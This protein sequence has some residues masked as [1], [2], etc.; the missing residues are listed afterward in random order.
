MRRAETVDAVGS[1]LG[2]RSFWVKPGRALRRGG[3]AGGLAM[4]ALLSST[5][6]GH[7]FPFYPSF[8]PQE[9]R[10]AVLAP[11][12]AGE[13]LARHR[14]HAYVGGSPRFA[15]APPPHLDH[16]RSLASF[17]VVTVNPRSAAGRTPAARCATVARVRAAFSSADRDRV[18]HGWPVTPYHP[19]YLH[20][21][22]RIAPPA[23]DV[24][25]SVPSSLT[26][27]PSPAAADAI[28]PR[29]WPRL[30]EGW[31]VAIDEVGIDDVTGIEGRPV[32]GWRGPPWVKEGW[33]QAYRLLS[34]GLADGEDRRVATAAFE[35][36]VG[37]NYVGLVERINLERELL[38]RLTRTCERAV[39]GYRLRREYYNS[40]YSAGVENIAV[41][42]QRGLNAGTAVRTMKLKDFPWNGWL[43]LGI[44]TGFES[45]WNP[46]AGFADP[47]G[48][49][50]WGAVS[51]AAL[52]AIPYSAD[53]VGNRAL[54]AREPQ[55][56]Q[57]LQVPPD[58]LV[59]Q[60]GSGRL[61]MVGPGVAAATRLEYSVLASPFTDGSEMTPADVLYAY[62]F[63]FRWG[64]HGSDKDGF[65]PIVAQA[66]A[67]LRAQLVGVRLL[68]VE[69]GVKRLADVTVP[70]TKFIFEVY[71]AAPLPNAVAAA[72]P[73]S[74]V[75]WHL[76]ALMEEASVRG[77]AAFSAVEAARRGIPSVD[78]VRDRRL[79]DRLAPLIDEFARRQYRPPALSDMVSAEAAQARW[80]ALR[81]F[82]R[83]AGHLLVANGP[84]RLRS[85]TP[86]EVV[87]DVVRE[88]TYPVG[89]GTF[90]AF[91]VPGRAVVTKIARVRDQLVVEA[92]IDMLEP[93][94][95]SFRA[96]RKRLAPG[97][98]RGIYAVRPQSRY[99]VIGKDGRVISAGALEWRHDG[100]FVAPLPDEVARRARTALAAVFP[101]GNT[102][103]PSIGVLSVG[104]ERD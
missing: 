26:V 71:L 15:A 30:A 25:P 58:A 13:A 43:R 12:A 59:P 104:Y 35:R 37:G 5:R 100:R 74:A 11:Q 88:L 28:L 40:E 19:D 93:A 48:R 87:L 97:T 66:T 64:A 52:L 73:W 75:P 38:D 50:L 98:T 72:A 92:D 60:A 67:V 18:P 57:T 85:W 81:D 83:N 54:P 27:R 89:L 84:Y 21:Y 95:R 68:R 29:S 56:A 20:H 9:I 69:R 61:A 70:E 103:D 36:L 51:D 45:A 33:Y 6:A 16:V 46:I 4:I 3:A 62:S 1:R 23:K 65:D 79:L 24:A 91:V 63:A 42:S 14:L 101:D 82:A 2:A 76:L 31:D 44:A 102:V 90:N 49:L 17:I 94:Q 53:W 8:Y 7:E 80:T 10:I 39:V 99:L 47:A 22:D 96:V 32:N 77:I 34:S 86:H 78:L 55:R 41:D